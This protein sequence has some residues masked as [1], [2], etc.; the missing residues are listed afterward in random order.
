MLIELTPAAG[1]LEFSDHRLVGDWA[2]VLPAMLAQPQLPPWCLYTARSNGRVVGLGAFKSHPDKAGD[3]EI[4][5]LTLA[6]ERSRG[7]AND[8]CAQLVLI[9]L[10]NDASTVIAHTLPQDNA[11]TEVLR[12]QGFALIGEVHD[13]EDGLVWRWSRE[14]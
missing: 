11:S 12:R 6:A 9:A 13:P 3:V 14:R 4:S 8:V 1:E 7:V 5:Y 10:A 2:A